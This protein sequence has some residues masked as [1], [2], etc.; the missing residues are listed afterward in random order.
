M[1]QTLSQYLNNRTKI[2]SFNQALWDY[3]RQVS[4]KIAKEGERKIEQTTLRYSK[5]VQILWLI[6]K[7]LQIVSIDI[8]HRK[9]WLILLT[10]WKLKRKLRAGIKCIKVKNLLLELRVC[11]REDRAGV[12]HAISLISFKLL[13][14]IQESKVVR[15]PG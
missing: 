9:I 12:T 4:V 10:S 13:Q 14:F 3:L 6:K 8:S 2:M 1:H 15:A 7:T 5:L 11:P